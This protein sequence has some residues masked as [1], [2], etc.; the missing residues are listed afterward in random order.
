MGTLERR[1]LT[2]HGRASLTTSLKEMCGLQEFDRLGTHKKTS[3]NKRKKDEED[4]L[5]LLST[6]KSELMTN[7][8]SLNKVESDGELLS[9][10]NIAT[11]V[12]ML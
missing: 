7:P 1:F 3:T 5:K 6:I 4:V 9:L 12:A 2:N 11:G 10:A 8:F